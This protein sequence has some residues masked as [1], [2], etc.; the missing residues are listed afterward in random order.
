MRVFV[1]T[2]IWVDHFRRSNKV[3]K[4]LLAQDR[5]LCHPWVI[6]E[7]ACGT[8]PSPREQTISDLQ[9]LAKAEV[10]SIDEILF[11]IDNNEL[12]GKGCGLIDLALLAST[13]MTPD[14]QLW[15]LDKRLGRLAQ[16]LKVHYQP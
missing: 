7:I 4:S 13:L 15:T 5:V 8:P 14:T 10:A 12:Y 11:F 2:S 3:L 16:A 1:D 6:G 9:T